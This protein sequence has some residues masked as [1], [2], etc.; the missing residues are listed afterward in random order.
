M[1]MIY[2]INS[3]FPSEKAH[4]SQILQNCQSFMRAG[5]DVTVLCPDRVN[6]DFKGVDIAQYYGL[7]QPPE[8]RKLPCVDLFQYMPAYPALP[9]AIY[10]FGFK[11]VTKTFN[12]SLLA[13]LRDTKFNG[14]FY[15]RDYHTLRLVADAF[16]HLPLF[17][18][19]HLLWQDD[20]GHA[21]QESI[22][23]KMRGIVVLTSFMRDELIMR[24]YPSDRII[25]AG[26]AINPEVFPG[27]ADSAGC[28][29]KFGLPQD[30]KIVA[31]IGNFHSMGHEK[32]LGLIV[33]AMPDILKQRLDTFFLFVGGPLNYAELTY[34]PRLKGMG[35][36]PESYRFFD[37]QP[38]T[39]I[40][41]WLAASDVLAMPLPNNPKFSHHMSPM[42]MFEYMSAGRP[43]VASDMPA[44]TDVLVHGENALM[45][46]MDDVKALADS[47]LAILSDPILAKKLADGARKDVQRHTWDERAARI[48]RFCLE[49][50]G[51]APVGDLLAA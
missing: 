16:P 34:V 21:M 36:G 4:A 32:G 20:Q 23:P 46:P 5:A 30:R 28:R 11:V 26:D 51:A 47:I 43:I 50:A 22:M 48:W 10:N 49:N 25:V 3:R 17:Y 19:A 15:S 35:I 24:G 45:P 12:K 41:E 8:I 1:K 33:D 7:T 18:E 6:P 39:A 29:A 40:H 2:S 37:R 9:G 31:Y 14:I 38:Y 13:Y 42:K 44:L 27:T